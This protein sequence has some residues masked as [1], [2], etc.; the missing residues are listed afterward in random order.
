[1][2]EK[3]LFHFR[4]L[5]HTEWRDIRQVSYLLCKL[6]HASVYLLIYGHCCDCAYLFTLLSFN[7]VTIDVSVCLHFTIY[8]YFTANC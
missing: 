5:K 6:C 4:L 8:S 7:D 3:S 2:L 1:M